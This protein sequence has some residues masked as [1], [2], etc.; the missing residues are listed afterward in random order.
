MESMDIHGYHGFLWS[1]W[2]SME[3]MDIHGVRGCPWTPWIF[4]SFVFSR[5]G[6]PFQGGVCAAFWYQFSYTLPRRQRKANTPNKC[7]IAEGDQQ[8]PE[9]RQT[10]RRRGSCCQQKMHK[11]ISR[12]RENPCP[13]KNAPPISCRRRD[14]H[15]KESKKMGTCRQLARQCPSHV[16]RSES[17]K[18]MPFRNW[19]QLASVSRS[20]RSGV[21]N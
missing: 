5:K 3:F 20:R 17:E 18:S 16:L 1:P 14:T 12:K 8:M 21:S 15:G 10:R 6:K 9:R 2:I 19:F 4:S 13:T 11:C 7:R